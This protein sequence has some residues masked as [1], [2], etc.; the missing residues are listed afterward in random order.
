MRKKLFCILAFLLTL[1]GTALA[2]EAILSIDSNIVNY[3][4][5]EMSL[6][7][8]VLVRHIWGD[9]SSDYALLQK[10]DKDKS[11]DFHFLKLMNNVHISMQNGGVFHCANAELNSRTW[12]GRFSGNAKGKKVRYHD[13]YLDENYIKRKIEL[14]SM[15]MDISILQKEDAYI[16]D[17]ILAKEGVC[18]KQDNIFTVLADEALFQNKNDFSPSSAKCKF[19]GE[20][21]LTPQK[22]NGICRVLHHENDFIEAG[23]IFIDGSRNILSCEKAEGKIHSYRMNYSSKYDIHFLTDSLVWEK[24][25]GVLKMKD[26]VSIEQDDLGK[27]FV[28]D[29]ITLWMEP[30]E[31]DNIL[32]EMQSKGK[33]LLTY[34]DISRGYQHRLSSSGG[35]HINNLSLKMLLFS[36][37]QDGSVVEGRQVVF[38]DDMGEVY[39][40]AVLIDYDSIQGKIYPKKIYIMGNVKIVNHT[41]SHEDSQENEW[42]YAL[43][44]EVEIFFPFQE[45]T[46]FAREDKHVL[47]FDKV[48][49]IQ[50]SAKEIRFKRDGKTGEESVEGIGVVRFFFDLKEFESLKKTF[51]MSE[52]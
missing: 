25:T 35:I 18:M 33:T 29:E 45:M 9:L 49:N 20:L 28:E 1:C 12:K 3:N 39:G 36:P 38:Q 19:P 40:D 42:Q 51:H 23:K 22:D 14:E 17:K 5:N 16:I 4:G 34:S 47:F 24:N 37:M 13:E 50:M 41:I 31:K 21:T 6:E 43:A 44:D 48:K 27:I 46:L 11:D 7:G 8:Q 10:S 32:R 2:K 26:N 30:L 15:Y 52:E